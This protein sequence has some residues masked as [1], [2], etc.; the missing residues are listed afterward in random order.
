M[1]NLS[2]GLIGLLVLCAAGAQ[3]APIPPPVEVSGTAWTGT[4][5]ETVSIQGVGADSAALPLTVFFDHGTWTGE[6]GAGHVLSGTYTVSAGTILATYDGLGVSRLEDAIEAWIERRSGIPV[7]VTVPEPVVMAAKVK[8]KGA[9]PAMLK[10]ALAVP[11]T[12]TDGVRTGQGT[13]KG[14]GSLRRLF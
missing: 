11:F 2:V 3:G 9:N 12:V 8:A 7:T 4:A 5:R 1:R 10:L 6:D 13:L 14:R